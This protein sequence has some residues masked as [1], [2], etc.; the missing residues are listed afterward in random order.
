MAKR[1]TK[2]EAERQKKVQTYLNYVADYEREFKTWQG[3]TEK[4][5][6]RYRDEK[7]DKTNNASARFNILWSNVQTL[8]PAVYSKLPQPDVSR[9]FRDN[10]PVGRVASLILERAL[11]YEIQHYP[12]YRETMRQAVLDRFLGGRG[13]AWIRYEPHFRAIEG[14]APEPEMGESAKGDVLP[15]DGLG[16]TEDIDEPDEELDYECAP[17]DY[18]HWKDFGHSKGRTWEEVQ[19]VWRVCYMYRDAV[20]E[21]FGEDWAKRL[22][23]D[24]TPHDLDKYPSDKSDTPMQARIYEVWDKSRLKVVWLAKSSKEIIDERDDPLGLEGFFPCPKPLYATITNES[25]VPI[26]D[27]T[28][29]QDQ[30]NSLDILADRIDGLI[31]ALKVMGV[32]NA[33]EP[34]LARLFTEG[35][36]NSLLPVKNWQAFSEKNGL[37]GAVDIVD[38]KPIYE[39]LRAAYE[40]MQ[41]E[42]EMIYEITGIS[43]IVRGQSV[44]SETLGA[45]QIKENFVGLRLGDMKKAVAEFAT[46]ALRLK[47]QVMCGKF[48]P[49]T[50]MMIS[51]AQQLMPTDQ[52]MIPQAMQLLIG[53]RVMDPDADTP[54]PL[55]SFRVEI[56]ADS[57]VQLNEQE[58]KQSRVEFLTAVG[59]Y[60]QK[61]LPVIESS[62][63]AGRLLVELL[64][65]GVT[66]FKVGKTIEG[67]FDE[68]LDKLKH[69][70]QQP[71]PDPET[72]KIQGEQQLEQMRM[73]MERANEQA[74]MQADMAIERAKAQAEMAMEQQR[75]AMEARFEQERMAREM[76]MERMKAQM[77]AALQMQKAQLDASTKIA[78]AEI[79]ADATLTAAQESAADNS[80]KD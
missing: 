54:N 9:R 38:L 15:E 72:A 28:L 41:Q 67:A 73:Q 40:A 7:R 77:D 45:Q 39:A 57:L 17:L 6:Q 16:V 26:P 70:A 35:E 14:P 34:T 30:A 1:P 18:V 12:D 37:A 58:E 32:Y 11:E 21:R 60:L 66:G 5:I 31:K 24:A 78:V 65:F 49:D 3:R 42:K 8:V 63:G 29:Y 50:L 59:S 51:A 43:D 2:A 52:Q 62:P 75:M 13:T 53:D 48:A 10:D 33:A 80:A 47:A 61:A 69:G 19:L 74:R 56:A 68:A 22:N 27:F 36:N 71:R 20:A 44:A 55:R 25:L 46:E 64:K 76:E 4:I 79:S 23:Y